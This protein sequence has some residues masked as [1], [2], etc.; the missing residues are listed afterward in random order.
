MSM[1]DGQIE[2]W[3]IA[4]E[5]F[6]DEEL[7]RAMD[8][9]CRNGADCS[10]IQPNQLCHLPNSVKDHASYAFNSYYQNMKRKGG[11]CYFLGAAVLTAL[12]PSKLLL[13]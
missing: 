6:P 10:K 1:V 2:D 4:D 13:Y 8:W 11:T 3:C 7:Q 12:N 9:A 5:Q